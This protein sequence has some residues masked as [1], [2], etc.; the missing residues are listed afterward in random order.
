VEADVIL[1]CACGGMTSVRGTG[2]AVDV[3]DTANDLLGD[4]CESSL[5]S[6]FAEGSMLQKYYSAMV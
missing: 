3:S 4:A 6:L 5:L 1:C 2:W